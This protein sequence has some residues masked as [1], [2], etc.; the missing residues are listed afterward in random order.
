MHGVT[1]FQL[2]KYGQM[3]VKIARK[4]VFLDRVCACLARGANACCGWYPQTLF[5]TL[6]D[7][8]RGRSR[9]LCCPN[10]CPNACVFYTNMHAFGTTMFT[11]LL[12]AVNVL[13][14]ALLQHTS[15]HFVCVFYT[16]M[17]AFCTHFGTTMFTRLL[18]GL[19][20]AH[21]SARGMN[22]TCFLHK[23]ACFLARVL[24]QPCLHV[25]QASK[26]RHKWACFCAHEFSCPNAL[27]H[28]LNS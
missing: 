8:S 23:Y 9:H 22:L 6:C 15:P 7:L 25:S 3:R 1:C 17:H 2:S 12:L 21:V 5:W 19:A 24:V 4:Q 27:F 16:N 13:C 28:G 20:L 11:R 10:K 14:G 26:W 18:M